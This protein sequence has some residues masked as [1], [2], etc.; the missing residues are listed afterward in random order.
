MTSCRVSRIITYSCVEKHASQLWIIVIDMQP[1][2]ALCTRANLL[3]NVTNAV[4]ASPPFR[5][6]SLSL[7]F[8]FSRAWPLSVFRGEAW[9]LSGTRVP[10]AN[11]TVEKP[12]R[13]DFLVGILERRIL[14]RKPKERE[15]EF[16]RSWNFIVR[17]MYVRQASVSSLAVRVEFESDTLN[18]KVNK[19]ISSY[20]VTWTRI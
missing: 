1:R 17:M 8:S 6:L 7:S 13:R 20:Y 15:G 16:W 12:V 19:V 3:L 2:A 5:S 14:I 4:H 18:A 10:A 9:M 11:L